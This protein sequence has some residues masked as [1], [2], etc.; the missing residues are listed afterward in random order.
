MCFFGF[1]Q[2]YYDNLAKSFFKWTSCKSINPVPVGGRPDFSVDSI[3]MERSN[4]TMN[5]AY[6]GLIV[7]SY[8]I[9]S[10][11][12]GVI[13]AKMMRGSDP[14]ESGSG[15]IG[16]TNV[17]RTLGRKAGA[18]TLA[19][20][21]LKGL[22]PVLAAMIIFPDTPS[23]VFLA[24]GGAILGHDFS[25]FLKFHGGKGVATTFGCLA[26]LNPALAGLSLATWAVVMAVTRYSSAGAIVAAALS[27]IFAAAVFR[28]LPLT[29]FC[30]AAA[31]LLTFLHKENLQRLADG[32]EKRISFKTF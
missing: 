25:I 17:L 32:T 4:N 22:V 3:H 7:L 23:V 20:D 19:G 21:A 28:N 15:N 12:S 13:V 9:G 29:L 10:I 16:A 18:Y 14:R 5:I 8:L 2:V 30:A 26:G 1:F 11:P 24:A 27:P 31:L 6:A